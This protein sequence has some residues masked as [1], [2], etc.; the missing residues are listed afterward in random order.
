M[1]SLT[2]CNHCTLTRIER[3][4]A[5]NDEPLPVTTRPVP[6]SG[7]LEYW[8]GVFIGAE[9]EPVALFHTLTTHCVC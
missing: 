3:E 6:M 8:M 2:L 5:R 4:Q 1:S 7:G 9:A